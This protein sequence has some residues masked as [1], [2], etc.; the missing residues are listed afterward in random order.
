MK[1]IGI[2]SGSFNPIHAG[3]I[4]FGLQAIEAANLDKLYFLPERYRSNMVDISH[5]G[6]RVS[7]IKQAIKPHRAMSIL[8]TNEVTFSVKKTWTNLRHQ[9]KDCQLVFLVGS[10]NL[11]TMSSW[12]NVDLLLANCQLCV[13]DRHNNHEKL[14]SSLRS[15]GLKAEDVCLVNSYAPS[16]NSDEIREALRQQRQ[17]KGILSSVARYSDRNWLYISLS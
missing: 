14:N 8:E 5:L 2:F 7:M 1:R 9:F 17:T 12:S 11:A 13:G 3:H 6:H 16:V 4:S 15:I 10:D